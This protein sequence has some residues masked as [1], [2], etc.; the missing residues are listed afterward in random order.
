M[1]PKTVR[2]VI[3]HFDANLLGIDIFELETER[4]SGEEH[5]KLMERHREQVQHFEI[6]KQLADFEGHLN[7]LGEMW[8]RNER[9]RRQRIR[10][11]KSGNH[12][13]FSDKQLEIA[14]RS[15]SAK[16]PM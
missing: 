12:Y 2:D 5:E 3:P 15:L 14:M 10:A 16:D 8:R 1:D 7:E 11:T 9:I 13:A 6:K 4:F